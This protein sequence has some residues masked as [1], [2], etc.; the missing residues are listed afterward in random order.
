MTPAQ[1]I[2]DARVIRDS[3]GTQHGLRDTPNA[4]HHRKLWVESGRPV[5]E[6]LDAFRAGRAGA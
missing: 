1:M 6:W 5:D 3:E 2:Q 4:S